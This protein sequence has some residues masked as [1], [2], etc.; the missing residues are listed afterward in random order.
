LPRNKNEDGSKINVEPND[1]YS[2]GD[3]SLALASDDS[4]YDATVV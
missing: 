3:S 2:S 4:I 1:S